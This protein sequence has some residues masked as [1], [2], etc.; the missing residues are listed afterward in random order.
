M[1]TSW[2]VAISLYQK[3]VISL[4]DM[5]G[6]RTWDDLDYHLTPYI[7]V[8]ISVYIYIYIL[9]IV[10]PSMLNSQL[11]EFLEHR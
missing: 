7:P 2:I 10:T 6:L 3:E 5:I 9:I 4:T 11:T 1:F 8:T